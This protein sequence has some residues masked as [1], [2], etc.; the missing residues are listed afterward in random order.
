MTQHSIRAS[1]NLTDLVY[2]STIHSETLH[3]ENL[4]T[5]AVYYEEIYLKSKKGVGLVNHLLKR[6]A[7]DTLYGIYSV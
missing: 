7:R 1:S 4:A 3:N 6:I 2:L 5:L